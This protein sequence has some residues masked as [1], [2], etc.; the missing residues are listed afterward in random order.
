MIRKFNYDNSD[1][2]GLLRS[3]H[4]YTVLTF[5]CVCFFSVLVCCESSGFF[6]HSR[7]FLLVLGGQEKHLTHFPTLKLRIIVTFLRHWWLYLFLL[8]FFAEFLCALDYP[9]FKECSSV[10]V[11]C[12]IRHF[13]RI[14]T[15]DTQT[16]FIAISHCIVSNFVLSLVLS[17]RHLKL[18][19]CPHNKDKCQ[20]F[21]TRILIQAFC[22]CTNIPN[23][24]GFPLSG[25]IV[26]HKRK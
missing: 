21:L 22:S 19:S 24:T 11:T 9:T 15:Y 2:E 25:F 17:P 13:F 4:N 10:S 1:N 12:K 8:N 23:T 14:M 7:S 16:C 3:L 20:I 26:I 18:Q 5:F 6:Y